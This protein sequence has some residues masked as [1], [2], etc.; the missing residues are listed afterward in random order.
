ML[1][2][3]RDRD[4]Y[5]AE[6]RLR[7]EERCRRD[8]V[9]WLEHYGWTFDPRDSSEPIKRFIPWPRQV[10]FLRW[11]EERE[12]RKENGL[13]DKSRDTGATWMCGAFALHRW[14]YRAGSAIGFGSRKLDL[15]D[16]KGDPDC[17]F[18][19]IRF[20]LYH[21]PGWM[22]PA[23]FKR[24]GHDAEGKLLNP[25]NGSTIT[26]EGGDN[27]G[28]G[29]RKSHYFVDE[30]PF[31]SHPEMVDGSLAATTEVRIDVG[32]PNGPGNPFAQKRFSGKWP[33]F[34]LHYKDDPRKTP[35]WVAKKKATLDSLTWAREYE[36]D[37]SASIEGI[38]IPAAWVR[39]AVNLLLPGFEQ[40]P[41]VAGLDVGGEGTNKSVLVTR[42]GPCVQHPISWAGVLPTE[43]AWRARDHCE[44][45][46]VERVAY[47]SIG[48]GSAVKGSWDM[49]DNPVQ[50]HSE[51]VQVGLPPSD[52]VWPDG[53]TSKEK[54][55]NI[56]AELWW[57]VRERFEKTFEHVEQG[58]A[59]AA[60]EMISLPDDTELIAQLS[61]PLM[62]HTSSGKMRLE[63]K[64]ELRSRGVKSPDFADALV[65]SFHDSN[66][67]VYRT[68]GLHILAGTSSETPRQLVAV[69]A[70]LHD[71]FD[72][73]DW[74]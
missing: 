65:L 8:V 49:A 59:H 72:D 44:R 18:E 4:A 60:E 10:E 41:L 1:A 66:A 54:F 14:L 58:V 37:Y 31:L 11:L 42:R 73:D 25:E 68:R 55:L 35:E 21:L 63:S 17:I 64:D 74:E 32:T 30:S 22:L 15:V 70:E 20:L 36:I 47:D 7:D 3:L 69:G 46:G 6:K 28:R 29:G 24:D 27:I 52:A 61:L 23:G 9:Y 13:V 56:K 67:S 62:K 45:L 50:F 40:S 71:G 12:D 19:K 26:A 38:C 2:A 51:A 57:K 43:T 48:V 53:R 39:S 33:V 5:A 34:T 16:R